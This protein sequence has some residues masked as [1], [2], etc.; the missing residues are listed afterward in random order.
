ME[1]ITDQRTKCFDYVLDLR[2]AR[3]PTGAG[4][5]GQRLGQRIES[6]QIR[7]VRGATRYRVG[8]LAESRHQVYAADNSHC[9]GR[10]KPEGSEQPATYLQ[11]PMPPS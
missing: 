4:G 1:V 7:F 3:R 5:N 10:C 2:M 11:L 8:C 9:P 6:R